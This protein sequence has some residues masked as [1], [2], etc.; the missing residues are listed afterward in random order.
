[1]LL[2]RSPVVSE[3]S[4]ARLEITLMRKFWFGTPSGLERLIWVRD[5]KKQRH[6][7]T[8]HQN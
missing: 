2:N 8:F 3:L 7:L 1:M 5:Y 4:G 6:M